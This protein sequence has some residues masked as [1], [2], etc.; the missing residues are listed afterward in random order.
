M[1]SGS[2][3]KMAEAASEASLS[4]RLRLRE[5]VR[6]DLRDL[7]DVA[8]GSVRHVSSNEEDVGIGSE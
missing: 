3:G 7:F 4:V 1:C 5:R 2:G 8:E 6:W